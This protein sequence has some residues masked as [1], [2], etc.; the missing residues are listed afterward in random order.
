M[1]PQS[2]S[3]YILKCQANKPIRQTVL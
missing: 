3:L 2:L 1:N